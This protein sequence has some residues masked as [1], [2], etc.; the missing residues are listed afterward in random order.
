MKEQAISKDDIQQ[1]LFFMNRIKAFEKT[2]IIQKDSMTRLIWGLLL[3]GAGILDWVFLEMAFMSGD[4]GIFISFPWV[5]AIFSGLVIQIFS[6]RHITNI[7]SWKKPEKEFNSDTL[8]LIAGFVIIAML[9][10]Y[11]SMNS[12]PYLTYPT[13]AV[14][15]GFMALVTDRSYFQKNEEILERKMFLLTPLICVVA[16]IIMFSLVLIDGSLFKFHG[17]IF[18]VG[19]GGN[20]SLV[21][22]LNRSQIGNYIEN[23]DKIKVDSSDSE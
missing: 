12:L 6:D 4:S 15:I 22:Y 1:L 17:M 23:T 10:I 2:F 7:Y 5:I 3:L 14:I 13:V 11:Y 16:V 20:L 19:V 21:A 18:G 8:F 9:N